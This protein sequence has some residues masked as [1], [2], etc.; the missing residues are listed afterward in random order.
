MRTVTAL[1]C[2]DIE[3][4]EQAVPGPSV[5]ASVGDERVAQAAAAETPWCD[6]TGGNSDDKAVM[7]CAGR[8]GLPPGRGRGGALRDHVCP[9]SARARPG[10]DAEP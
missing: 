4:E 6:A 2:A 5:A 10:G 9:T 7:L 8:P 3:D 1:W